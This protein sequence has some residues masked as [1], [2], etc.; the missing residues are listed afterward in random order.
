[1]VKKSRISADKATKGNLR[2]VENSHCES[3]VENDEDLVENDLRFLMEMKII[4]FTKKQILI[5][6]LKEKMKRKK[7]TKGGHRDIKNSRQ[8]S[9][10]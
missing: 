3:D 2:F 6:K 5:I 4:L 1:M 10:E 8:P 9:V 7:K